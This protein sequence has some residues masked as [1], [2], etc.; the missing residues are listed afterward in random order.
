MAG[1]GTKTTTTPTQPQIPP[2]LQPLIEA[3]AAQG[4]DLMALLPI[5]GFA[6]PAP[7]QI[8]GLT[9]QQA[10]II[11]KII[12]QGGALTSEEQMA[13]YQLQGLTSGPIGESP[14]TKAGME[15]WRQ[16][17]QPE[18]L[19]AEALHGRLGGGAV[20]E[21]LAQSASGAAVP[22]I[23]QEISQ[24]F[25]AIPELRALGATERGGLTT[26]L[27][28]AGLPREVLGQQFEAQF[29]DY[30]RRQA[31]SES[32]TLGPLGQWISSALI[33]GQVTK[34]TGGGLIGK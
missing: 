23:Q 22:L 5:S 27:E 33:P 15:A 18:V 26:A 3:A 32:V 6:L 8:P 30:L 20:E 29:R 24:R 28:A 16:L 14:T 12:A 31:L 1:G 25:Q 34:T 4:I 17:V 9:P 2:Q 10:S 11:D 13:L 19:Q 21:A 7:Q